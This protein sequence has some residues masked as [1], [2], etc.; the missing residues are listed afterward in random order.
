MWKWI[1]SLKTRPGI[2][3]QGWTNDYN[4]NKVAEFQVPVLNI[5]EYN[6]VKPVYYPGGNACTDSGWKGTAKD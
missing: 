1:P 6:A 3:R 4:L 2:R 5:N